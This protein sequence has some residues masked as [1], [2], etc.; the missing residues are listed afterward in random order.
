MATYVPQTIEFADTA[1]LIAESSAVVDGT[2][3]EVWAAIVDYPAWTTWMKSVKGCRSTSDPATGVGSTR[4]VTLGGGLSFDEEFIVWDE[5]GVWAFTGIAGPPIFRSLVERVTLVEVDPQR[6][7]V[8]YR[9]AMEA[10][11][12][13]APMVKLARGGIEKNLSAS[14]QALGGVIAASR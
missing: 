4:V 14:L 2:R 9:M 8:T 5:P 6:T 1:P 7:E 3:D 13:L 11:R 12:G 10:R